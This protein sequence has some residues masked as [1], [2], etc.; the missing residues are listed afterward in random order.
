[1][2]KDGL[3]PQTGPRAEALGE[4]ED[5]IYLFKT[6]DD[7]DNALTNWFFD[8]VEEDEKLAL[9]EVAIPPDARILS[10]AADYEIVVADP[11]PPQYI[12]VVH[13]D[14]DEMSEWD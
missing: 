9:L 6:I 13:E 2:P 12:K 1:M 10:T 3:I 11:I 4:G 8:V 7:V 14:L 5:G